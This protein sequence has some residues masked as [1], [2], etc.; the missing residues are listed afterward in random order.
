MLMPRIIP[1]LTF[2][3]G[4]LVKTIGFKKPNYIG[5]PI[6]AIKLFNELE[7]DEL[8]F[9]DIR[10]SKDK[11]PIDFDLISDITSECFMPV[12]YGGGIKTFEEIEKL[13]LLGIEKIILNTNAFNNPDLIR[14]AADKYGSQSILVSVDV[15]KNYLGKY[16]TWIE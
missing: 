5:D 4:R 2:I 6:N 8:V 12:A 15:K 1:V 7:V 14:R 11:T 13:F 3:E 9:L 16:S 10:A